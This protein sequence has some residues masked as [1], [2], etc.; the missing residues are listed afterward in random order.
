MTSAHDPSPTVTR[1]SVSTAVDRDDGGID[2]VEGIYA[3][4]DHHGVAGVVHGVDL[5]ARSPASHHEPDGDQRCEP[6]D[7]RQDEEEAT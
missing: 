1:P 4:A 7:R 3:T 6:C 2:Q 5:A